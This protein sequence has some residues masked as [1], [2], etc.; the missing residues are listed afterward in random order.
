MK[1]NILLLTIALIVTACDVKDYISNDD[2]K[3]TYFLQETV[4]PQHI[5]DSLLQDKSSDF[6]TWTRMNLVGVRYDSTQITTYTN[7]VLV[8]D[9]V[10]NSISV[11]CY[12][13]TDTCTVKSKV[14]KVK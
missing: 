3:Y 13:N 14:S 10:R 8:S 9:S 12:G 5:V 2:S 7:W 11:T 4:D 6:R 1:K